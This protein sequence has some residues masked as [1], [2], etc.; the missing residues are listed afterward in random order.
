MPEEFVAAAVVRW[1]SLASLAAL[2]GGLT[3]QSLIARAGDSSSAKV[4][5]DVRRWTAIA[6]SALMLATVAELVIRAQT[7]TGSGAPTALRAIPTV[8][9]RTHFGRMWC[10]RLG[11]LM[12]L[13]F[14]LWF[15]KRRAGVTT[16]ALVLGIAG[17]TV[18]TGHA[19]DWGDVSISV[20]MD[21][22]HLVASTAWVGGL[23]G[24]AL[25]AFP[26]RQGWREERLRI[27]L[28][29]FSQLAGLC[30]AI[31]VATGSY[32]SW[33][34]LRSW[35]ALWSTRYGQVLLA[36][37]CLAEIGRAHV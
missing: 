10:G 29:Q 33:V 31:V 9:E 21:A 35:S 1:L 32:N 3:L 24:L 15:R 5:R 6:V 14:M 28:R 7:L 20:L 2:I 27:V 16:R 26:G 4:D 13:V 30:L 17:T 12:F 8:L 36:K 23:L 18:V 25:I 37:L 19:G 34:Q 11:A 22:G